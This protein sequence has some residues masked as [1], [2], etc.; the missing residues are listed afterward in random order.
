MSCRS[1]H[2]YILMAFVL[3]CKITS[4]QTDTTF[5]FAA[6][7]LQQAHG[8]RPIFLRL[9]T[10]N[11]ASIVTISQPANASFTPISL[12][13]A[14][15]SSNSLDLTAY[16]TQLENATPNTVTN[17][18]LLI[19]STTPVSCYYDIANAVSYTHLTLPTK[20]IV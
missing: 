8:D 5:W 11:A 20:R 15:N 16:I 7:D 13:I 9:S 4:A 14:A 19:R 2:L 18:G 6:P 17:K 10:Q 1:P 3:F 12:N